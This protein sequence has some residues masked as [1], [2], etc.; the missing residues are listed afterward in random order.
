LVPRLIATAYLRKLTSGKTKPAI[1]R[2]EHENGDPAGEFVVKF[3]S[4]VN[5]GV[6]GLTCELV[7]ALTGQFL[8]IPMPQ[9]GLI[10]ID[11]ALGGVLPNSDAEVAEAIRKS[12]GVNFGTQFL[13]GGFRTWPVDM[14]I[15][16]SLLQVAAE[17]F[18]FDALIQNPD[19]RFDNPN[20]LTRGEEIFAIDH[21]SAF[22]FIY[23]IG[24]AE[25]AWKVANFTFLES[26]V[27]YQGL[28]GRRVEIDRFAGALRA[29]SDDDILGWSAAVPIEWKTEHLTTILEHLRA[30]RDHA[31]EFADEVRRRLA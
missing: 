31:T 2:C 10:A 21:E 19:R 23:A 20:V 3:K 30:V 5:F 22:S 28:K 27:F 6:A 7:A 29:I 8:G 11:A 24:Q 9:A 14:A 13:T 15:P 25:P 1:F 17:I 18:A 12:A 4:G 16:L 26:H